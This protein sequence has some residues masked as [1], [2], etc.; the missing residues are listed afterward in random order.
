M[1]ESRR[2]AEEILVDLVFHQRHVLQLAARVGEA[3]VDEFDF[4]VLDVLQNVICTHLS[5]LFLICKL[6]GETDAR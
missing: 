5:S 6:L 2:T 3:Q 4:V 1:P